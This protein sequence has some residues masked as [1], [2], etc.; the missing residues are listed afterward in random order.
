MSGKLFGGVVGDVAA[1]SLFWLSL[2]R[3]C[4]NFQSL[5]HFRC[6]FS[7]IDATSFFLPSCLSFLYFNFFLSR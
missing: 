7:V 1:P 3:F 5:R 4:L 6:S 2:H